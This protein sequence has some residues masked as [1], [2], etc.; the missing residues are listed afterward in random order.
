[1]RYRWRRQQFDEVLFWVTALVA[2]LLV[3]IDL[4]RMAIR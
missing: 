3:G 1:M 4:A 2:T